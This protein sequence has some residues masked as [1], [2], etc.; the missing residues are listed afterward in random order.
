MGNN[1][2]LSELSET[3]CFQEKRCRD[4]LTQLKSCDF[5]DDYASTIDQYD[6]LI[7][8]ARKK[9]GTAATEEKRIAALRTL[10]YR[11]ANT[12]QYY[13]G[14]MFQ[15]GYSTTNAASEGS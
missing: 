14:L 2:L 7:E 11:L 3:Q 1:K 13:E 12:A 8:E 15:H 5:S 4:L 9:L 10:N 6:A